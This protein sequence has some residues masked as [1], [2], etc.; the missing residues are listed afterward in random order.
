MTLFYSPALRGFYDDRI[1]GEIP[2][3]AIE[4]T[5]ADHASL[6]AGQSAGRQIVPGPGGAPVLAEIV[7]PTEAELLA[8]RRAAMVVSRFQ[9]RAALLGAGLLEAAN[10]AVAAADPIV[11]IAWA[12]AQEFRRTSPTIAALGAA[13]GLTEAQ[14]DDLFAAA[15]LIT[16]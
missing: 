8:A 2:A 11:Q 14:I 12:D 15:A 6:I 10:A 3:D 13:L 5:A 1:H 9:A 7:A 4:I 16:A